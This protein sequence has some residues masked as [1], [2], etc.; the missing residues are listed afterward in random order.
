[1]CPACF[2]VGVA[3]LALRFLLS[4]TLVAAVLAE[5]ITSVRAT[6]RQVRP[7]DGTAG[8]S[9]PRT[10][11]PP[12]PAK[13]A[14]VDMAILSRH[15]ALYSALLM[16]STTNLC[17]LR[18]LPWRRRKFDNYPSRRFALMEHGPIC[19][20]VRVAAAPPPCVWPRQFDAMG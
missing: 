7:N 16:L 8:G 17:L 5:V 4:L 14:L 20:G 9:A 15:G 12:A 10:A 19:I 6:S 1:M 3:D 13:A 2:H 18:L 11:P